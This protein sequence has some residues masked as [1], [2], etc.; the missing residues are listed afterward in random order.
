MLRLGVGL[1]AAGKFL[2]LVLTLSFGGEL[3]TS[4]SG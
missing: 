2:G 4:V 1:L 3:L